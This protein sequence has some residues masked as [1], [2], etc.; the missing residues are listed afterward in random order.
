MQ[1]PLKRFALAA[2]LACAPLAAQSAPSIFGRWLTQDR[3]GV[4]EITPCGAELCGRIVGLDVPRLPNGDVPRDTEGRPQC[5][6]Q[7]L[8]AQPAEA[9]RWDGRITDPSDGTSWNCTLRLDGQGRLKLRGYVLAPL[10]GQTQTWTPFEG[11]L[12]VACEFK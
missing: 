11:T 5:G 6:L 4:V 12:G 7:I 3:D 1:L 9:G 8:R 2:L 10:F